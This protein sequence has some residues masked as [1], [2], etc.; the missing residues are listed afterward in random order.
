MSILRITLKILSHYF[1]FLSFFVF[2]TCNNENKEKGKKLKS[3]YIEKNKAFLEAKKKKEEKEMKKVIKEFDTI[4]N[5]AFVAIEKEYQALMYLVR[6]LMEKKYYSRA[7]EVFEKIHT[8]YPYKKKNY[9][10]MGICYFY[11]YIASIN[12]EKEKEYFLLSEKILNKGLELFP[13]ENDFQ[14]GLGMLHGMFGKI[15]KKKEFLKKGINH[16]SQVSPVNSFYT[17]ALFSIAHFSILVEDKD[18]AIF[19]YQKI[20][21]KTKKKSKLYKQAMQNLQQLQKLKD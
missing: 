1:F 10:D 21:K 14:Y 2:F 7:I 11:L 9:F 17:A 15:N 3:L 13:D 4:Y 18:R 16:L 20:I 5:Y 8:L 6:L 19:S 12:K